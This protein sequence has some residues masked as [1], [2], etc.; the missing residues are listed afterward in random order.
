VGGLVDRANCRDVTQP[1][2]RAV[3]VCLEVAGV[4]G[5]ISLGIYER[6]LA[7]FSGVMMGWDDDAG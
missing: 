6:V 2:D 5:R 3:V 1:V 4:F 7:S